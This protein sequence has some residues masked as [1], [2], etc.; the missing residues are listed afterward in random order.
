MKP[1]S[2]PELKG[3]VAKEFEAKIREQ[4]SP[5]KKWLLKE[6]SEIYKTVKRE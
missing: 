6:A 1:D 5:Q 4:S 3:K 2:V